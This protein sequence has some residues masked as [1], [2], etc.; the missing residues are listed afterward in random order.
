[1]LHFGIYLSKTFKS[2]AYFIK[3]EVS[4]YTLGWRYIY[5]PSAENL[6]KIR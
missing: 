3:K 2:F 6:N 4:V 5:N 1:M